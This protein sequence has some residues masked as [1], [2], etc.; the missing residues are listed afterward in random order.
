MIKAILIDPYAGTVTEVDHDESTENFA[1]T[2]KLLSGA[3]HDVDI[4]ERV[5]LPNGDM[6]WLD[7]NGKI[8]AIDGLR[9]FK[10]EGYPELLAGRGLLVG[11]GGQKDAPPK[12]TLDE[13]RRAVTFDRDAGTTMFGGD[14]GKLRQIIRDVAEASDEEFD[15]FG[16]TVAMG[17]TLMEAT[18]KADIGHKL[19]SFLG[20]EVARA[21]VVSAFTM[22]NGQEYHL[23]VERCAACE[24]HAKAEAGTGEPDAEQITDPAP[25]APVNEALEPK[26]GE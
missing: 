15:D 19:A 18:E 11:D 1:G 10:I 6:I 20:N 21:K 16:L 13:A 2:Y 23:I 24:E 14:R 25:G 5:F 12:T 7:E 17:R 3:P 8:S 26:G 9:C 22:P 4:V